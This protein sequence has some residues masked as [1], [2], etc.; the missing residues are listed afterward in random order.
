D[1]LDTLVD[2]AL[3]PLTGP[4]TKQQAFL[5]KELALTDG[6]PEMARGLAEELRLAG[7]E[8]AD[9][10]DFLKLKAG[11]ETAEQKIAELTRAESSQALLEKSLT[12]SLS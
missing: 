9:P 7:V 2:G 11:L 5:E 3:R 12:E 8:N 10:A 6:F 1:S 4:D